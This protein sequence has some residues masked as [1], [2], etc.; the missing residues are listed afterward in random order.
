MKKG[1]WYNADGTETTVADA[2]NLV[3]DY[4]DAA[5]EILSAE[6][7]RLEGALRPFAQFND[8]LKEWRFGPDKHVLQ[9]KRDD[10]KPVLRWSE[11]CPMP[12]MRGEVSDT[13]RVL[14]VWASDFERAEE[15]LDKE[16]SCR[17]SQS[18]VVNRGDP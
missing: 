11:P 6:I 4:H 15:A 9:E 17:S 12:H 2:L 1:V 3:K 18:S 13:F 5:H 16:P 7:E 14:E 8:A 10:R